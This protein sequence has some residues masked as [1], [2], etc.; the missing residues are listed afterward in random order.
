MMFEIHQGNRKVQLKPRLGFYS[1]QDFMG[2]ELPGLAIVLDEIKR[3]K[4]ADEY[5]VLTVNFG[6]F[7]GLKNSAYIDINNCGFIAEQLFQYDVAEPTQFTKESG[8]CSY[9]L[10]LFKESFLKEIGGETYQKYSDIYDSYMNRTLY[11]DN[12]K[13][14]EGQE[15]QNLQENQSL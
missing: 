10:W 8:F 1:T 13:E 14:M 3:G 2:N 9:P 11:E 4:V 6:E 7:I 12:D 5:A 15:N